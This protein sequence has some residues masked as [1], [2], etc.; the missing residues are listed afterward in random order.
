MHLLCKFRTAQNTPCVM[1]N[2]PRF[3]QISFGIASR[4][5]GAMPTFCSLSSFDEL[6]ADFSLIQEMPAVLFDLTHSRSDSMSS[7]GAVVVAYSSTSKAT[8]RMTS[9]A[10]FS[11]RSRFIPVLG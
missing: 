7:F 5:I 2:G 10:N 8:R 11:I 4:K 3:R 1:R 6:V 9:M